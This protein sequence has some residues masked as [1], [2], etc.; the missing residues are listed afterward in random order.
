MPN[1][2]SAEMFAAP[3]GQSQ[4]WPRIGSIAQRSHGLP[5]A[6]KALRADWARHAFGEP[7]IPRG[8]PRFVESRLT[9]TLAG[10]VCASRY[11][12][13]GAFCLH[14]QGVCSGVGAAW[15]EP[16]HVHSRL[17]DVVLGICWPAAQV[18][19]FIRAGGALQQHNGMAT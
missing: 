11:L 19:D 3:P 12:E 7:V 5:R 16:R 10:A 15:R 1:S 13:R 4:S 17:R 6:T 14:D 18:I 8:R 2:S 9:E